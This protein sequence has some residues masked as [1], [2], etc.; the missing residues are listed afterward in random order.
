MF[1]DTLQ[2]LRVQFATFMAQVSPSMY[3]SVP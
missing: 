1:N 3:A 2:E